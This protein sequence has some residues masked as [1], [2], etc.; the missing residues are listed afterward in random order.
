MLLKL[1]FQIKNSQI[2]TNVLM[3]KQKSPYRKGKIRGS[4]QGFAAGKAKERKKSS[5]TP[6]DFLID[7]KT[8]FLWSVGRRVAKVFS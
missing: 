1:Q 3:E 6:I 2:K 4:K 8:G 5:Y 7:I